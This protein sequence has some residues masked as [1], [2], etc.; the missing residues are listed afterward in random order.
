MSATYIAVDTETGGIGS[1]VS[2]LTAYIA[3]LDKNMEIIE[4]LNLAIKPDNGIYNVT[5]EALF[6]NKINLIEHDKGAITS[7][8]AGE[9]FRDFLIKHSPNGAIKLLPLGHNV[10]FDMDKLYQHVLNKKEAQK[11][12]SYRVLDTGSTGNFLK[13]AGYIPE[14]I[15]GGLGTYVEYFKVIKRDAHEAKNDT[16]MTIDV[17][18]A[19]LKLIS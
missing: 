2:L 12:I 3:I 18:K 14:A 6:I 7:G 16:L 9:L 8:K 19:M 10:A 4:D 15:S 13:A 5:A 1:D 17:M 11:Y